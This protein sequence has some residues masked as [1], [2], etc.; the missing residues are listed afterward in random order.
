MKSFFIS[1]WKIG[2]WSECS[3][4][5]GGGHKARSVN[6]Q[7]QVD[8]TEVEQLPNNECPSKRPK[9][10]LPCNKEKCPTHWAMDDWSNVSRFINIF[11]IWGI[12]I[13]IS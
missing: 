1:R 13:T 12:T 5:C 11:L 10:R 2:D 6:C 3:K 7:R 9:S 8:Q 4:T